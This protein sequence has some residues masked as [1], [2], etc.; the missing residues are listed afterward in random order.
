MAAVKP[1]GIWDSGYGYSVV[2]VDDQGRVAREGLEG[3]EEKG[4]D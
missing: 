3:L 4:N 1:S 2:E